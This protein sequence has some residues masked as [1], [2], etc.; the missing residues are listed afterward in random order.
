MLAEVGGEPLPTDE[1]IKQ[2][3]SA[4]DHSAILVISV[5]NT[6]TLCRTYACRHYLQPKSS[7]LDLSDTLNIYYVCIVPT[8]IVCR[9]RLEI[10]QV[11]KHCCAVWS[12]SEMSIT[13]VGQTRLLVPL[14]QSLRTL[15]IVEINRNNRVMYTWGMILMC[16]CSAVLANATGTSLNL[17][18][19]KPNTVHA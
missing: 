16:M 5:Y 15:I 2:K 12:R 11:L 6:Y 1:A 19:L 14:Q 4:V 9:E 17:S 13:R 3:C 10:Y 8:S 7:A 18:I